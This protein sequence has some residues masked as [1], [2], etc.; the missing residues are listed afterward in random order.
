MV[1][2]TLTATATTITTTTTTTTTTAV[3]VTATIYHLP[4]FTDIKSMIFLD[5]PIILRI[6][7][8]VAVFASIFTLVVLSAA[9]YLTDSQL[10]S[11]RVACNLAFC[12]LALLMVHHFRGQTLNPRHTG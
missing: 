1:D 10:W 5:V 12:L 11:S 2:T 3:T 7:C 9:E 6:S 8:A 4:G